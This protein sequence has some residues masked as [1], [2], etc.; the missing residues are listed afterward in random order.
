VATGSSP[1]RIRI[2]LV[3]QHL[4][5]GF[6]V[7]FRIRRISGRQCERREAQDVDAGAPALTPSEFLEDLQV[8]LD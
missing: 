4:G 6:Q 3:S 8:P 1:R 5:G 7:D 2:G